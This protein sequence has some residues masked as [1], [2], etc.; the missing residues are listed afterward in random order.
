MAPFTGKSLQ[1]HPPPYPSLS[2]P[3]FLFQ[4]FF[5]ILATESF[6][7]NRSEVEIRDAGKRLR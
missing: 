2:L 7:K 6:L 5:I 1:I 4:L 3:L